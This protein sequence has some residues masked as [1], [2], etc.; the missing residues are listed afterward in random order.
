MSIACHYQMELQM[1]PYKLFAFIGVLTVPLSA[2]LILEPTDYYVTPALS[3]QL[4]D[5]ETQQPVTDVSIY[6]TDEH[7]TTSDSTG[8]FT[9]PPMVVSDDKRHR[10]NREQL[11]FIYEYADIMIEGDGYQRRLFNVDGIALLTPALDINTPVSINM[12]SVYLTPLAEGEHVYDRVY[13]YTKTMRY[14]KPTESQKEVDCIPV[15]EGKT[16]KQVS[17]NQPVE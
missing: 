13:Q 10:R 12:G 5:S 1:K 7:Q 14:C 11:Q 17:P 9:L 3:G 6:L 2:C 8:K 16:Y 4:L 15:P